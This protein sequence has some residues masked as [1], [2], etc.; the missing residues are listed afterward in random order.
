MKDNQKKKEKLED[1]NEENKGLLP[2]A[3]ARIIEYL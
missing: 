2:D 1:N 3:C